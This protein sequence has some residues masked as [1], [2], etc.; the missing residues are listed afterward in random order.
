MSD[1]ASRVSVLSGI[2]R[3]LVEWQQEMIREG[4]VI[5]AGRDIGSVVMPSAD[6]KIF[7]T[8]DPEIR[9]KRR[10]HK[11]VR[12]GIAVSFEEVLQDINERDLRD[13]TRSDSPLRQT[14]D[15][16]VV[17]TGGRSLEE[18]VEA[19]LGLVKRRVFLL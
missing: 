6:V 2:R 8:A 5:M 13:S 10:F 14:D 1:G 4:G 16:L 11:L 17:D 18:N 15:A 7:L 9:A 3:L 12:K 19:V